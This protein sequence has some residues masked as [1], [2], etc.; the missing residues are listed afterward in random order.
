MPI[1]FIL[2]HGN[3]YVGW[4]KCSR[5][6]EWASFKTFFVLQVFYKPKSLKYISAQNT[7]ENDTDGQLQVFLFLSWII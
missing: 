4:G 2:G 1:N 7:P 3:R 5:V 6:D